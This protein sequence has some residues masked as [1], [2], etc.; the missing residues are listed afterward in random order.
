MEDHI[1]LRVPM[2]FNKNPLK[3]LS[4]CR[5][6]ISFKPIINSIEPVVRIPYLYAKLKYNR[7]IENDMTYEA[8]EKTEGLFW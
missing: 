6:K 1:T 4:N 8:L 7:E 3:D 5:K 2:P